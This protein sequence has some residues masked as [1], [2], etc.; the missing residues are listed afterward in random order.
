MVIATC[1]LFFQLKSGCRATSSIAT[2]TWTAA[3]PDNKN[4]RL[5]YSFVVK[6]RDTFISVYVW[7]FSDEEGSEV[8]SSNDAN[9]MRIEFAQQVCH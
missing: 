8:A 4:L 2:K 7:E 9:L 3:I 5:V 6:A 1:H